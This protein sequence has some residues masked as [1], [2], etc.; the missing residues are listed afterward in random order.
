MMLLSGYLLTIWWKNRT[1]QSESVN[2][3]ALYYHHKVS[4]ETA[5]H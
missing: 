1:A 2:Q 4:V 5:V 3:A